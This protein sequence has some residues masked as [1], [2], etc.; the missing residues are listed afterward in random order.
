MSKL[1]DQ[2]VNELKAFVSILKQNPTLLHTP[3]LVFFKHYVESLGATIPPLSSE[4]RKPEPTPAPTP[5]AE[6]EPKVEEDD[7]VESDIEL[8]MEGVVGML[9]KLMSKQLVNLIA[10]PCRAGS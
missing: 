9:L 7:E 10:M 8:D 5:S 1:P 6:P 3:Q 4:S 2:Q